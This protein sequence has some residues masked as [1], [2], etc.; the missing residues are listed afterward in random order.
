[1]ASTGEAERVTTISW[2]LR[3]IT[4][5]LPSKVTIGVCF[6]SGGM[7]MATVEESGTISGRKE[8]E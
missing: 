2:F 5:P 8:R 6:T 1:M 4:I 7:R 3:S